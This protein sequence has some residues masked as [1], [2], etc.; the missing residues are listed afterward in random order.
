MIK[1]VRS[2]SEA[3]E[4]DIPEATSL[5]I[6]LRHHI[7]DTYRLH[8]RL[9]RT[10]R[11]DLPEWVLVPRR[12]DV[13]PEEDDDERSPLMA[14][15][16]DSW[17]QTAVEYLVENPD[18]ALER[19][20]VHRHAL[21][22]ETLGQSPEECERLLSEMQRN[23]EC[24]E[25]ESR[26]LRLALEA[27]REETA[28]NR[29]QL[30]AT[31]VHSAALRT[32]TDE[33]PAKVVAMTSSSQFGSS[34]SNA[35]EECGHE[36]VFKVTEQS[37]EDEIA[38]AVEGFR[39]SPRDAVLVGDRRA[40]EGLNL[41]FATAIVHA[42]LPVDAAR[43][44]QRIGRVDRF[45]RHRFGDKI[46]QWVVV[47]YCQGPN[48]WM[49]WFEAIRDTFHVFD[50]SI[51]ELQFLL[52]DLR[53]QVELALFRRGAQGLTEIMEALSSQI[54]GERQRLDEEY[55][56]DSRAMADD[57]ANLLFECLDAADEARRFQPLQ[58]FLVGT[59]KFRPIDSM[60]RRG[61]FSLGWSERT[62]L[63]KEPWSELFDPSIFGSNLTYLRSI[64]TTVPGIRLVRPGMHLVDA[65][66]RFLRWDD[67]G[68]AFATWR[69]DPEWDSERWGRWLGFRLSYV[70]QAEA[71]TIQRETTMLPDNIDE[72]AIQRRLDALLPPWTMLIDVGLDGSPINDDLLQRILKRGYSTVGGHAGR[73]Y[74]LG[75]RRESL[76]RII[77]PGAFQEAVYRTRETGQVLV[78]NSTEHQSWKNRVVAHAL[79]ALAADNDRLATRK[80]G[81]AA[82]SSID[83]DL[84]VNALL[85]E[86]IRQATIRLDAMGLFVVSN[87]P[88]NAYEL[89]TD[90]HSSEDFE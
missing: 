76:F 47:P 22:L 83:V 12:G 60:S 68:I 14:D 73:D 4:K 69:V 64:A 24:F 66:E 36:T 78:G 26:E 39:V 90:D 31:V 58:R 85:M 80:T 62:L 18:E 19:V 2:L 52:D 89:E 44:E 7:A 6:R 84:Q 1:E 67:R 59:L 48:P 13:T 63:P 20:L 21:M 88:P 50:E 15:A 72:F 46:P 79:G 23:A 3:I 34:L 25:G 49:A 55:A 61:V 33:E 43:I 9:V 57:D 28:G 71:S 51:S 41:Q 16:L 75:S 74:N 87:S 53:G 77:E 45:G 5:I 54:A 56:L 10:R 42:D 65:V 32:R 30:V 81:D 82:G 27:F 11:R 37:T 35:V 29:E 70:V 38:R 8:Q 40:E 86:A 17:R